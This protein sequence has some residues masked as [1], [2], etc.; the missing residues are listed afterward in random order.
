MEEARVAGSRSLLI[1]VIFTILVRGPKDEKSA[2]SFPMAAFG[3][4]KRISRS[5]SMKIKGE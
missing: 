2:Q 1:P 5:K 4:V 3:Y